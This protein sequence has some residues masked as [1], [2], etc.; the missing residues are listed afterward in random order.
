MLDFSF[1]S[2][3]DY[4]SEYNESGLYHVIITM[5]SMES[6]TLD[7]D[8]DLEMAVNTLAE[9]LSRTTAFEIEY[10]APL[11]EV[12][13]ALRASRMFRIV[14]AVDQITPGTAKKLIELAEENAGES[15]AMSLYLSRNIIFE[16]LRLLSRVFDQ[17]RLAFIQSA[18]EQAKDA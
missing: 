9:R 15:E 10:G 14:Q 7:G 6:W 12:I 2:C 18:L 16:R 5:E 3:H 8:I 4:W 11:I 17:Q 13:S 1:I